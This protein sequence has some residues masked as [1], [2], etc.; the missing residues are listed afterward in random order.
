MYLHGSSLK[1]RRRGRQSD[2]RRVFLLIALIG[3]GVFLVSL[4]QQGL[5]QPLFQ[6]TAAPTRIPATFANE[7]Q[8]WF[9][10]GKLK[11]AIAAYELATQS[12]PKNLDYWVAKSRIEI[13]A[14]RYEDALK[15]AE[16]A[17]LL[18]PNDAKSKTALAWA[19]DWNVAWGCRCHTFSEAEAGG[20]HGHCARY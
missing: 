1:L 15:T 7:G 9:A 16:T 12:D 13:Y 14:E 3:A 11:E 20:G 17:V 18:A 5:V 10:S 6:P 2:P 4:R 19:M 8:A